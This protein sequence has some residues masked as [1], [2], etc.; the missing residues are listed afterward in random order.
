M[1]KPADNAIAHDSATLH[2]CGEAHYI[3]DIPLPQNAL[4]AA[5]GLSQ[6]AH[7]SFAADLSPVVNAPGQAALSAENC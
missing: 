7:A 3:D 1:T 5:L 4:Y 6:K 2:V